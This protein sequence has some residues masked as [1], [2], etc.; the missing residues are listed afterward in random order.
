MKFHVNKKVSCFESRIISPSL[1]KAG[2]I[3]GYSHAVSQSDRQIDRQ[4]GINS[5]H[6]SNGIPLGAKPEDTVGL[7]VGLRPVSIS[8]PLSCTHPWSE[9]D[10]QKN[11]TQG[12]ADT[13]DHLDKS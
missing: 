6:I 11:P 10:F 8:A 9:Q 3:E 2:I 4:M 1:K 13:L 5:K 7:G 12:A